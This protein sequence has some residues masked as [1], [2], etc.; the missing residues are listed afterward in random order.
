MRKRRRWWR[1]SKDLQEI[2]GIAV[3]FAV[4]SGMLVTCNYYDVHNVC[5]REC[6]EARESFKTCQD[7]CK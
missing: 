5:R 4:V 7:V 3:L 6:I 2:L 1:V